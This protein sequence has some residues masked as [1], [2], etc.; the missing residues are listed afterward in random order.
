MAPLTNPPGPVPDGI[1]CP[2]LEE[3]HPKEPLSWS[4]WRLRLD[5]GQPGSN[6]QVLVNAVSLTTPAIARVFSLA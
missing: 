2:D 4:S 6:S 1:H 5:H 3:L